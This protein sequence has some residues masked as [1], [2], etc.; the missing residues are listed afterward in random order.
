[1]REGCGVFVHVRMR[2]YLDLCG[3]EVLANVTWHILTTV[4]DTSYCGL[5]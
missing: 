2:V 5:D 3:F 1:M 4:T